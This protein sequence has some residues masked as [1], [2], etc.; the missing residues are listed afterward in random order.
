MIVSG[1]VIVTLVVAAIFAIADELG[2]RRKK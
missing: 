1:T 2:R